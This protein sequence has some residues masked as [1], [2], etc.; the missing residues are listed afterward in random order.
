MTCLP[1]ANPIIQRLNWNW[2]FGFFLFLFLLTKIHGHHHLKLVPIRLIC[3]TDAS[4][5]SPT[6]HYELSYLGSLVIV[7]KLLGE[8]EIIVA[9]I[10]D[11]RE[12]RN[13]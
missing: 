9:K 4:L 6:V 3:K 1:S 2:G 8:A 11:E 12:E 13:E 7:L 5:A 10:D